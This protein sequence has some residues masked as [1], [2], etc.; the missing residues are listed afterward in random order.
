L[1]LEWHTDEFMTPLVVVDH[2]TYKNKELDITMLLL[3]SNYF[4]NKAGKS[5]NLTAAYLPKLIVRSIV[6][7]YFYFYYF[8]VLLR[9]FYLVKYCSVFSVE[10][11]SS[12]AKSCNLKEISI[13]NNPVFLAG[14]CVSFLVSY[15][16]QLNKL[17]TMQI[18]EQVRKAA[19]AWRRNKESTNSAFMDLTSDV[20]LNVRREEIISNARTNW[21]LLRSQ[22]KCLTA[23]SSSNVAKNVNNL[24]LDSD[25]ILTSFGKTKT[26]TYASITTKVPLFTNKKL[27]RT[28]SQDTDNSQN[29]SSSNTSSNEFI[30]LPPIL[31][32]IIKKM[33]QKS[34]TGSKENSIKLSGSLSSIGPNVDSSVSSLGSE[35]E[36]SGSES[37][38]ETEVESENEEV[39]QKPKEEVQETPLPRYWDLV[40]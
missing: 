28:S 23:K 32:P 10:D 15:L 6:C 8:R 22:T 13:D 38:S 24:S 25:L 17:N 34:E 5:L 39:E 16:P 14:D 21:E 26:K 29:T 27:I 35:N 11:I 31:L 33:E 36:S 9:G 7:F 30:R 1:Y 4:S 40:F 18:T 12:L 37:S 20:C 19:M 3:Q 2:L